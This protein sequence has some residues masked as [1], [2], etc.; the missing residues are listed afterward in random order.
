MHL[1]MSKILEAE[2]LYA[3]YATLDTQ[4]STAEWTETLEIEG[5]ME[6]TSRIEGMMERMSKMIEGTIKGTLELTETIKN[7]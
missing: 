1:M 7:K 5:T 6:E 4:R 2:H 3:S